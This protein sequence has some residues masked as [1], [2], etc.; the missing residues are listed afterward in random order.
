MAIIKSCRLPADAL[1]NRY[2]AFG[3]YADCYVTEVARPV[4]HAEFVEAFYT[5]AVFKLERLILRIF[6]SR[7]STDAQAGELARGALS[8]FAAWSVEGR[9]LNQVLL[10][11]LSGRTRSWLMVAASENPDFTGTRL[12]FGSAVVPGHSPKTGRTSLGPIFSTLMGFHKLYSRVLLRAAG[13]RLSRK[14]ATNNPVR[15]D[16]V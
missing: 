12:Y 6:V 14:T 13:R 8:S 3:A 16:N 11:D 10:S 2:L 4:S 15:R 9:A 1:L 7:P 5:T